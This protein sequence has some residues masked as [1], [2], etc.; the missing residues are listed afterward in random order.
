MLSCK[1]ACGEDNLDRKNAGRALPVSNI[2][3]DDAGISSIIKNSV[4]LAVSQVERC[5]GKK[6][7]CWYVIQQKDE[8]GYR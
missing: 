4:S 5:H 3:K 1:Q 7:C 8:E 6:D 2:N